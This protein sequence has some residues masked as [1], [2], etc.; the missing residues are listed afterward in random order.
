[1]QMLSY[2]VVDYYKI[3]YGRLSVFS[4]F[5]MLILIVFPLHFRIGEEAEKSVFCLYNAFAYFKI[6]WNIGLAL[7]ISS[8]LTYC[9]LLNRKRKTVK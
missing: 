4:V 8:H 1:M 9:Y 5:L 3:K 2:G 7:V 6:Y